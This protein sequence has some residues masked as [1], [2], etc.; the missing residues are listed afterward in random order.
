MKLVALVLFM[1]SVEL[2]ILIATVGR[3]VAEIRKIKERFQMTVTAVKDLLAGNK[4]EIEQIVQQETAELKV[5]FGQNQGGA[6]AAQLDEI[7]Q[8]IVDNHAAA[9]IAIS[10]ISDGVA[11][12][13][14]PTPTPTPAPGPTA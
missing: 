3:L 14:G 5:L 7:G 11:G 13:P 9:K 1:V 2:L 6:T 10:T 8:G 4:L 12:S